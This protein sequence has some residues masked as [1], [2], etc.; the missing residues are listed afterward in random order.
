MFTVGMDVD[1]RAYFTA[2]TCAI[3]LFIPLG[4]NTPPIFFSI[5]NSQL[6]ALNILFIGT[7]NSKEQNSLI[8]LFPNVI[9][10]NKNQEKYELI[11]AY[12]R[13]YQPSRYALTLWGK[14]LGL[15]SQWYKYRLTTQ[16]MS[17]IQLTPRVKSMLIGL[18]LSDAWLQKRGHWNPRIACKQSIINLP[19][20]WFTF[21]EI[22]YY[23]VIYW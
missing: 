14:P 23:S 6:P 22:A 9:K 10:L 5:Y 15:S 4:V 12:G 1:S 3:S 19:F 13:G 18:L 7:I 8:K 11:G 21:K 16:E 20:I 17:I 2:A